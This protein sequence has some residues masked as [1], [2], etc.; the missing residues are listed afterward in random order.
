MCTPGACHSGPCAAVPTETSSNDAVVQGKA[1]RV[2]AG[3]ADA[4]DHRPIEASRSVCADWAS[5]PGGAG[6]EIEAR[7]VHGRR[8][9]LNGPHASGARQVCE[10]TGIEGGGNRCRLLVDDW[11]VALDDHVFLER[12]DLQLDI[13]GRGESKADVNPFAP[14][15]LESVQREHERVLSR[16]KCREPIEP[17][18]ISHRC[19]RAHERGTGD[20]DGDTGQN[21]AC[22]VG[23]SA[24][25]GAGHGA[26]RLAGARR[27]LQREAGQ[28]RDKE[29]SPPIRLRVCPRRR[30]P[31]PTCTSLRPNLRSSFFD[32]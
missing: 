14:D 20:H 21:C 9:G 1:R 5:E 10:L 12:R 11:R 7:H 22:A 15:C 13:D 2:D 18:R 19:P 32:Q 4:L 6:T 8:R 28:E 23:D 3:H 27:R 29:D 17:L 24:V 26:D 30:A 25:D 16:R 31:V